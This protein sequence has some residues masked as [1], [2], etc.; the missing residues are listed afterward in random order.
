MRGRIPTGIVATI[1]RKVEKKMMSAF[2]IPKFEDLID[3]D[4][5]VSTDTLYKTLTYTYIVSY[6]LQKYYLRELERKTQL[7]GELSFNDILRFLGLTSYVGKQ[8]TS[9]IVGNPEDFMQPS[10]YVEEFFQDYVFELAEDLVYL[11]DQLQKSMQDYI[12]YG[13][14]LD[15]IKEELMGRYGLLEARAQSIAVTETTRAY[16]SGILMSSYSSDIV[17]GY[18]FI[19][20]MDDHTTPICR[21]RHGMV[22]AHNEKMILAQNTPPLHVNCRSYLAPVTELDDI[23]AKNWIDS[24]SYDKFMDKHPTSVPKNRPRDIM[25]IENLLNAAV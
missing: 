12:R 7:A 18:E 13:M 8:A 9:T 17:R 19:A 16:A 10:P 15:K 2:H 21:P 24:E 4:I 11:A 6:V 20:V 1:S 25:F 5:H 3:S 14:P 23:S 22:I